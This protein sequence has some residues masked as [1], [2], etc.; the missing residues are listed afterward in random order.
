MVLEGLDGL[1]YVPCSTGRGLGPVAML[2]L[3]CAGWS[4][5]SRRER[6]EVGKVGRELCWDEI[7]M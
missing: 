4:I 3:V 1:P 5:T 2:R 7:L 6:W